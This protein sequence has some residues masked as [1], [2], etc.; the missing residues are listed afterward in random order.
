MAFVE[1]IIV[2]LGPWCGGTS[3]VAGV[4][5]HLGV[6]MGTEFDLVIREPHD[7][8]E[9]YQLALLCRRAFAAYQQPGGRL[10]MDPDSWR[11][12]LRGWADA[13]RHAARLAERQPGAK[14]PLLCLAV[15]A[16]R[17]AW[18]P[19]VPVVVD[20]PHRKVV[21]SLNRLGWLKDEQERADSTAHL[22]AARDR[23]LGDAATIR[24]DFEALR[25]APGATVRRLARELH[26]EATEAQM[27]AAIRSIVR[28]VKLRAREKAAD[29]A[30]RLQ[31]RLLARV[32]DHPQ[33]ARAVF[34][35]AQTLFA[36]KDFGNAKKW[37]A[38]RVEMGGGDEEHYFAM[39]Q[40]AQSMAQLGAPGPAVV[41]AYLRAWEFRP[42]RAE[43]L[44][45]VARR[46]RAEQRYRLG[47]LFAQRAAEIPCPEDDLLVMDPDI[48]GW[49]ALYEQAVCASRLAD[50]T[51][52]FT[53]WRRLLTRADLSEEDRQR[54][55]ANRDVFAPMMAE[56]ALSYPDTL[57]PA[58]INGSGESDVTVSLV[59]GPDRAV[60]ERTLNSFLRCCLDMSRIG[61]FL[62]IDAGLSVRDRAILGERYGFL[63]FGDP[64]RVNARFWLH[65][66][67]GWRFFA[68]EKLITRLTAV[69]EEEPQVCQVGVNFADAVTLTG[70]C[71]AEAVVRRTPGAGRYV[72]TDVMAGGP[73]MFDTT[74]LDE[75]G[76]PIA[77][78]AEPAVALRQR[79]ITNG[80]RTAS[81]DEVLCVRAV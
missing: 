28:P 40:I 56:A 38:R 65:L 2:V 8:W 6:F 26:L 71:A 12:K 5:H 24:V 77:V 30:A 64:G 35:L 13:H 14:N 37:Y 75:A 58:L 9:D 53:L 41:D 66:G 54:F 11:A 22:I 51:E 61:R 69:L 48:Y 45:A 32:D 68:P 74:R 3:A 70:S 79:M 59:A 44:Y 10:R 4:L 16:V 50:D 20:R 49:R 62:V 46:Y 76:G 43:P 42:T 1:P 78:T 25:A 15:E 63:E 80:L 39:W 52:A 55:A 17:D 47:Y 33:D 21:A 31:D 7:T 81:L 23:A 67:Q 18:G 36:R 60:A 57:V 34:F 29:P 73:A 72:L 27:T 19:V